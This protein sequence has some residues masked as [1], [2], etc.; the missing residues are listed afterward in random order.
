MQFKKKGG[1]M[2]I[3]AIKSEK[4]DLLEQRFFGS[5]IC[6]DVNNGYKMPVSSSEE[7]NIVFEEVGGGIRIFCHP[8]RM[9]NSFLL[10]LRVNSILYVFV[11]NRKYQKLYSI[12][13]LLSRVGFFDNQ[14]RDVKKEN[15][16]NLLNK[17]IGKGDYEIMRL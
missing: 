2:I 16:I 13:G 4:A 8:G 3:A 7:G 9:D 5:H 15:F 12:L 17:E 1:K 14:I 6:S 10:N 11:N